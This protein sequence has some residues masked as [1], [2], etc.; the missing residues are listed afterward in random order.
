MVSDEDIV[1]HVADQ[2]IESDWFSEETMT[3]WD[4]IPDSDKTWSK[5][6]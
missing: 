3:T 2:I 5:C 1:I 4:K 6:Q